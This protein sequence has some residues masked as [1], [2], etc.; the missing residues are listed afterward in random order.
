MFQNAFY[1]QTA[2]AT[3]N[4][5]G[6]ELAHFGRDVVASTQVRSATVPGEKARRPATI[7]SSPTPNAPVP[8]EKLAQPLATATST[9]G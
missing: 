7:D 4:R 2:P 1:S 5:R 9:V 8:P 6:L 3:V